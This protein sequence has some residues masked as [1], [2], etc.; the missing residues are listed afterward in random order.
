MT[1][2][3]IKQLW[4]SYPRQVYGIL[5]TSS[6]GLTSQEAEERLKKYGPNTIK[7]TKK[8]PL[9]KV[10]LSN[11]ISPMALLLWAA[12]II[13]VISSFIGKGTSAP[14]G[15][16]TD[17]QMFYLG[18]AIW[19]VNI[20]NGVFSFLQQF[21][22]G[23]A[24]D[25]LAKMLPTYARVIRDGTEIRID[26]DKLVPGDIMILAEGDRISADARILMCD[27]L[28]CAQSAL[29]GEATPARKMVEPLKEDPDSS[30]G[31]KNVVLAGTAVS[32]GSARA[33]VYATGMDTEFGKIASLTQDIKPK[34]SHLQ[35]DIDRTTKIIT[36]I[37]S[38][39]GLAVFILGILVN[40]FKDG[41]TDPILYLNQ[42]VFALGILVA[43]IPEGLSPTVT[44]SL[45]K[46]VQRMA[47]EGALIKS[48]T[49]VE[50]L[51]STTVICSDKTGTLTKNEMTVKSLYFDGK[52]HEVT[53]DG[54]APV[55]EILSPTGE[56]MTGQDNKT[57]KRLLTIGGL[58]SD[59][60]LMPPD[61][62]NPDAK[63]TVLGDPTEACLGVA[64]E[65][66]LVSPGNMNNLL[67]RIRELNFDSVRKMMT[68]IH[69]LDTPVDDCQRVAFT[70]GA[71]KEVLSRCTKICIDGQIRDITPADV[72]AAMK[73]NDSY[74][75]QGLRVLAM[76]E[77]LLPKNAE[78]LPTAL[79]DY[80][81]EIIEQN[82][83][84]VGLEAMQD[85]PRDG[86]KEAIAEC[87]KAGIRII[88][89]TGDYG[90][91]ALA[92]ARKI[93]IVS[94]KDPR[95]I[96]GAELYKLTDDELK[97]ALKSE[98]IFARMAPEQKY[99][100]VTNLQEMGHIVAVTGDGVNDAPAL[101]KAD[102]GVAMGITG[103]DVAKDA[104]DMIL[105]DD[106]FAS[107]VKAIKEGRTVYNNIRKFIT[108]I[109]NSNVPEAIPFLLPLFTLNAV[110]QPLT[111]LEVLMIDLGTD[112]IPALGLGIEAPD[113]TIMA[114]KPRPRDAHLIDKK[115]F[116][117]AGYYGIQTTI[118]S[119][120]AFFLFTL[121]EN[122]RMSQPFTFFFPEGADPHLWMS[123]TAVVLTSIVFCQI[124]M[125]F[126][127]RTETLPVTKAGLF[128]NKL[129]L[130]GIC[131]EICIIMLIVFLPW[132]NE[133]VFQS[134]AI[135]SW[136]TWLLIIC[137]PFIIF[138][139][140]EARK[141]WMYYKKNAS[142]KGAK[143]E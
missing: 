119:M 4:H 46:A 12:G 2:E 54:Y 28:T 34:K 104:A 126:N 70:K 8:T 139:L 20:I 135:T 50:T 19:L 85:P 99:R 121:F 91:T 18:I 77:R 110:P 109:F 128:S 53:G 7:K 43:F 138:G 1:Q 56:R 122:Q 95:V 39:V 75:A 123:S 68:T 140:E 105:T 71:P 59:A 27:D 9:W 106:N 89:V 72:E 142:L 24:T 66:G 32:T 15:P 16:I 30:V 44:L 136:Q 40:G 132:I 113:A 107:I 13:S 80:T 23:K 114:E 97:E 52:V 48:L 58:C 86:I 49:S 143:T 111:V 117:R 74:A 141:Y 100:V 57:L 64:A 41:F 127:C 51:G 101:K 103:T 11:F 88:M 84:F 90:L 37:A 112:L 33:A 35:A 129:L 10:F 116:L 65:K 130:T 73:Q 45:A 62:D 38:C 26:A 96:T 36:I 17:P 93:G 25:A 98:I 31:A 3:Q 124:G 22:A 94:G 118:L 61:P 78:G 69:Q 60:R 120:A 82:L 6:H 137:F 83:V 115:L 79:S 134:Y 125:G 55:G 81:P 131:S 29:D 67:P 108:Y 5:E 63:Y 133:N 14:L 102:I 21:K 47:K 76:A 87:H 42:F 92:I